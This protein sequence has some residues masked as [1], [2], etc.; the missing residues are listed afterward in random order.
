MPITGFLHTQRDFSAGQV[1]EAASRRHDTDILKAAGLKMEETEI[2]LTGGFRRRGGTTLKFYGGP[3]VKRIQ[4][5]PEVFFDIEFTAG[6]FRARDDDGNEQTLVAPWNAGRVKKLNFDLFDNKLIVT[7]QGMVPQVVEYDE[8]AGTWSIRNFTFQLGPNLMKRQ[9]FYRFAEKGVTMRP[10]TTAVGPGVTMT[11]SAAVLKPTMVGIDFLWGGRR[12]KMTAYTSPTVGTFENLE[13]LPPSQRLDMRAGETTGYRVGDVVEGF[14]SGARGI[15]IAINTGADTLDVLVLHRFIGF[16][17][18]GNNAEPVVGPD[19]S[20][21]TTHADFISPLATDDWDEAF[22]SDFR[23]WPGNVMIDRQR[24]SF[25]DF[26]QLPGASVWSEVGQF[27]G[28]EVGVK[29]TTTSTEPIDAAAGIFEIAPKRERVIHMAGGPDQFVFTEDAIYYI[30]ISASNPLAPGSVEFLQIGNGGASE[31]VRPVQ[32]SSAILYVSLDQ[33]RIMAIRA[34]GQVTRPYEVVHT[35]RYHS[36]LI[37]TPIDMAV[38]LGQTV[39]SGEVVFIVNDDGTVIVGRYNA[40][41]DFVGYVPWSTVGKYVGVAAHGEVV[42][43]MARHK[44]TYTV[45]NLDQAAFLD[46]EITT[47]DK[48]GGAALIPWAGIELDRIVGGLYMGKATPDGTGFAPVDHGSATARWGFRFDPR[49]QPFVRN[50]EGGYQDFAQRMRRRKIKKGAVAVL[51]S[52]PFRINKSDRAGYRVGDDYSL[53]PK[54]RSDTFTF[55]VM[56]RSFEPTFELV[57]EE[58][59]P[60]KVIEVALEVTS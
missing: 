40:S 29:V 11:F 24:V 50:F 34:T 9:P 32:T 20:G 45:E 6:Q 44:N 54:L 56:G 3:K 14:L 58:P 52:G 60:L 39:D 27:D 15:V 35:S 2:M 30:P 36:E 16:L 25:F 26:I 46:C 43:L 51:E 31:K 53:P 8:D 37:K 41:A 23:G 18:V 59:Y 48:A 22:M 7:A 57:Q 42:L 4:P 28:F 38:S 33:Q 49:F 17:N 5:A 21:V 12:T 10:S 55:R 19:A 13:E 47:A 1:D